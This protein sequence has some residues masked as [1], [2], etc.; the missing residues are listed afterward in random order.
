MKIATRLDLFPAGHPMAESSMGT[1]ERLAVATR[2]LAKPAIRNDSASPL[3]SFWGTIH[4][5]EL[6]NAG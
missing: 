1:L 5:P 2:A 3:R 6:A 4:F